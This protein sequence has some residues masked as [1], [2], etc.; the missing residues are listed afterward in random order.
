MSGENWPKGVSGKELWEQD[1][2]PATLRKV[3]ETMRHLPDHDSYTV[4]SIEL[5]RAA[6]RIRRVQAKQRAFTD[7]LDEEEDP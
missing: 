2:S 4:F 1:I 3:A 6:E 7:A 5:E